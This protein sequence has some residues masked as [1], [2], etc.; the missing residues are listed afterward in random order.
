M[1]W[2]RCSGRAINP[3][4]VNTLIN[5]SQILQMR[6]DKAGAERAVRRLQVAPKCTPAHLAHGYLLQDQEI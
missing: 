6:G 3:N 4:D 5:H 2:P 1:P